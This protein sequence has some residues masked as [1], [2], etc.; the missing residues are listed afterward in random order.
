MKFIFLSFLKIGCI[1]DSNLNYYFMYKNFKRI[2][3]LGAKLLAKIKLQFP[4]AESN[5]VCTSHSQEYIGYWS[6][7]GSKCN[8]LNERKEIKSIHNN[9][10]EIDWF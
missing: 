3:L 8:S 7:F 10:F 4:N 2:R 5:F 6:I 1:I 9:G